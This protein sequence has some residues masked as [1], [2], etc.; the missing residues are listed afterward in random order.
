MLELLDNEFYCK[1]LA[2]VVF[3][4]MPLETANE[5]V[6]QNLSR[7]LNHPSESWKPVWPWPDQS[8]W[9]LGRS[10]CNLCI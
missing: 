5:E 3:V 4:E 9:M 8:E 2:I 1:H 7:E 10:F 6:Q